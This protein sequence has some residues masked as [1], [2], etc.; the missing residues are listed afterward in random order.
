[1]LN[2]RKREIRLK[3]D[4][5]RSD[6]KIIKYG[7]ANLFEECV[8]KGFKLIRYPLGEKSI[9]GLTQKREG[10]III[11]TNSSARLSR[12]IFTLAH[13]I[14]HICLHHLECSDFYSEDERTLGNSISDEKEQEANFFAANLLMPK[15]EVKK[16]LEIEVEQDDEN[17]LTSLDIAKVMTAFNVSFEM[18]LNRL[19]DLDIINEQNKARLDNEKTSMRVGRLLRITGDNG[20][21]NEKSNEIKIP[22]EYLDW[23]IYNYNHGSIPEE[24]LQKALDYFG[25]TLDDIRDKIQEKME[26]EPDLDI[27]IGGIPD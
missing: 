6:C 1:M 13:E 27:L 18:T 17:S 16:F 22:L 4:E 23:T 19:Q 8:R 24:T 14:G 15:E 11:F 7:I 25:L 20:R 26:E 5:F 3:A 10:D 2:S 21:L 9:L 12:E